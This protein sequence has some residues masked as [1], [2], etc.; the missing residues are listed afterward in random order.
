MSLAKQLLILVSA[1]FLMIFSLNFALSVSN[2]KDYLEGEA[3][4]HAQDTATS[5]GLSLSPYMMDKQ[6]PMLRTMMNAI[7]DM[8]YYQEIRLVDANNHELVNLSSDKTVAGVPE[9][10]I[11]TLPM[12]SATAESEISSGWSLS[13]VLYVTVNPSY[14]YLKLYQQAK[15]ALSFSLVTFLISIGLL[16][17]LLRMTLASLKTIDQLALAVADGQF[18][19]IEHLPWTTEVRNVATSMNIMS[20]KIKAIITTLNGKLES[21]GSKLLHDDLTG[22]FKKS[23][24]ETDMKQLYMEDSD[25]YLVL[26]KLDSLSSLVK[27]QQSQTIDQLLKDFARLLQLEASRVAVPPTKVYRFYGAEFALLI[28]QGTLEQV[29]ALVKSLSAGFAELGEK[30]QKPDLA[31]IGVA[32]INPVSTTEKMLEAAHEAYEQA[33]L[34]GANS[35]FIRTGDNFA[36]DI[37]TW[38][39]LVFDCVDNATYQVSYV[40]QIHRF[41]N[42]Q[43]LLEEAFTEVHDT[44]GELVAIGPFISIAEKFAKIIDLDKGVISKVLAHIRDHSPAHAIAVN[45]STRTIKNADFR[46]W[47]EKLI[48][49]NQAQAQQLVFSLSAYAVIKDVDAYQDFIETVHRWGGKVMIKRFESQSLSPELSKKL[50][51][52]YIRLAREIGHDLSKDRQK[53]EFVTAMQD[54][55]ALLDMAILAEN[56]SADSDYQA[57]HKI[58]ILGASR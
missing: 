34:I 24:F 12:S 2:T 19:S 27:E 21:M 53:Y 38:K 57:L 30:Y 47:L 39:E 22:L 23:V 36:R 14:A 8:G 20:K 25:A 41:D 28:R 35:Y 7:F 5:L 4:N 13:G 44:Q 48:K 32:T 1:L 10:F 50:K 49:H 52:D 54:M 51:P 46:L 9:W 18:N 40:G 15:S 33:Q 16:A 17:L 31:H 29:E 45:L 56:V 11:R 3:K 55:G 26:I 43:L 37:S 42:R 58:G 6:D